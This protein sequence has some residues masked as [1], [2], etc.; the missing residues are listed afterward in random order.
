MD[1]TPRSLDV[2]ADA[3]DVVV[4]V[5]VSLSDAHVQQTMQRLRCHRAEAVSR[6]ATEL[7]DRAVDAIRYH[8]AVD[9]SQL[10]SSVTADLES[11]G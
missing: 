9:L 3:V 8:D 2:P 6:L 11:A 1:S 5:R 7:E 4:T 10:R